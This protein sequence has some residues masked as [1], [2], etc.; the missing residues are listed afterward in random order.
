MEM[1]T[2]KPKLIKHLPFLGMHYS[3]SLTRPTQGGGERELTIDDKSKLSLE[4]KCELSKM[5][6]SETTECNITGVKAGV[7]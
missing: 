2:Q 3:I 1:E 4:K 7:L 6:P 5:T